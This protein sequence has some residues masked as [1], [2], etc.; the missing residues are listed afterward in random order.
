MEEEAIVMSEKIKIAPRVQTTTRPK[1]DEAEPYFERET[2]IQ[3]FNKDYSGWVETSRKK[4]RHTP[5]ELGFKKEFD[6]VLLLLRKVPSRETF[7]GE[8]LLFFRQDVKIQVRPDKRNIWLI[9]DR[10]GIIHIRAL[11]EGGLSCRCGL[12]TNSNIVVKKSK[13]K[14][15]SIEEAKKLIKTTSYAF[16]KVVESGSATIYGKAL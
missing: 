6:I 14:R 9:K 8:D 7:E 16:D 13:P 3:E 15:I 10:K 12:S 1:Y 4:T 5:I 11:N 2:V